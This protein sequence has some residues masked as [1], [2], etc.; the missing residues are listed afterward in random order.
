MS[1][2]GAPAS[3][4]G[5]PVSAAAAVASMTDAQLAQQHGWPESFPAYTTSD[6]VG[7]C[8]ATEDPFDAQSALPLLFRYMKYQ[9]QRLPADMTEQQ[10]KTHN[11]LPLAR[12]KR[13]MKADEDVRM[14]SAEAPVLLAKAVE[15]FVADLTMRS[16]QHSSRELAKR[17]TLSKYDVQL[18]LSHTPYFDFLVEIIG[19]PGQAPTQPSITET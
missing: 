8:P 13:I 4:E 15:M 11:D 17:K 10:Y 6:P 18:A 3:A 14:I 19:R 16:W 1:N 7:G 9:V 12:I 2:P 5:M